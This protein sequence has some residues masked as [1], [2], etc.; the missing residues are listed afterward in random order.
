[1]KITPKIPFRQQHVLNRD[2][3]IEMLKYEDYY[4]R[5]QGQHIYTIFTDHDLKPS[6]CIN[7]HVLIHFG[8]D[9]SDTSVATY[10]T[11]FKNYYNSPDDYDKEVLDCVYYMKNNKC[12]YYNLPKFKIG[13][14]LINHQLLHLNGEST[15][16]FQAINSLRPFNHILLCAFSTS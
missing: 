5:G 12:V 7:R 8:F 6:R 13:D 4:G 11:I 14:K 16:L 1:M 3:V 10:R 9:S 15:S 2:L